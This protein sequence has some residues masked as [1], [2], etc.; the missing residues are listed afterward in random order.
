[1][2]QNDLWFNPE[3]MVDMVFINGPN[4]YEQ[5]QLIEHWS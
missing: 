1:M 3:V 4:N 2:D 5:N